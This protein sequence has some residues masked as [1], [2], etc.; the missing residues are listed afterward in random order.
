MIR[1]DVDTANVACGIAFNRHMQV[2]ATGRARKGQERCVEAG[3][4]L[5]H[6]L[7]AMPQRWALD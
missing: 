2:G 7:H 1:G 3:V 6:P 4:A 5:P